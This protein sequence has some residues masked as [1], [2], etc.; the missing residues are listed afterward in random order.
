MLELLVK[1][2]EESVMVGELRLGTGMTQPV[3]SL[4]SGLKRP[5][6]NGCFDQGL[7]AK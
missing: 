5:K 7:T 3:T 6:Q 4:Q 2:L 1:K